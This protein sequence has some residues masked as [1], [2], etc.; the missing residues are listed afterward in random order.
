M[1]ELDVADKHRLIVGAFILSVIIVSFIWTTIAEAR[2]EKKKMWGG[3]PTTGHDMG[4]SYE[5][6]EF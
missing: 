2:R 1:I 5:Q 4:G 3:G 6:D